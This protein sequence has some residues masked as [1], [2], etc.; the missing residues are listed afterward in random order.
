[1][2]GFAAK[3]EILINQLVKLNLN[4]HGDMNVCEQLYT[5]ADFYLK[6][7]VTGFRMS[8]CN[9]KTVT[10]VF[11]GVVRFTMLPPSKND[12]WFRIFTNRAIKL[13]NICGRTEMINEKNHTS[14]EVT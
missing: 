1:M 12:L 14:Y 7:C 13:L 5:F 11:C 2:V 10:L 6:L 9:L 4:A 3:R 8:S